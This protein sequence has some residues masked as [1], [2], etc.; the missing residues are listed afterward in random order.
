MQSRD[1]PELA[2]A[3]DLHGYRAAIERALGVPIRARSD[4]PR[5]LSRAIFRRLQERGVE[6]A[7]MAI[8]LRS[9]SSGNPA[10]AVAL[11]AR[12][13]SI[14]NRGA[15]TS[16]PAR[17]RPE[18]KAE[19]FLTG[20]PS[21]PSSPSFQPSSLRSS[22][23]GMSPP[24]DGHEG[25]RTSGHAVGTAKLAPEDVHS[26]SARLRARLIN[27]LSRDARFAGREE[28]I[29][30]R[31][32]ASEGGR[33]D[34]FAVQAFAGCGVSPSGDPRWDPRNACTAK[35][36]AS[37]PSVRDGVRRIR[38]AMRSPAGTAAPNP[39]PEL[40][41][42]DEELLEFDDNLSTR[43]RV[44]AKLRAKKRKAARRSRAAAKAVGVVTEEAEE[45]APPA[46][47]PAP[48]QRR[49]R[50][51][52]AEPLV[53]VG[54]GAKEPKEL[55]DEGAATGWKEGWLASTG[56]VLLRRS[57]PRPANCP[58]LSELGQSGGRRRPSSASFQPADLPPDRP[59]RS[60]QHQRLQE[61]MA[62]ARHRAASRRL[63]SQQGTSSSLRD[64]P[65][66]SLA[67]DPLGQ[68][69]ASS[70]SSSSRH[71]GPP[72]QAWTARGNLREHG[73]SPAGT[74][75]PAHSHSGSAS[76]RH[77]GSPSSSTAQ[78]IALEAAQRRLALAARAAKSTRPD[79]HRI[80]AKARNQQ[81]DMRSAAE[82]RARA[83]TQRMQ[84]MVI[85]GPEATRGASTAFRMT[86]VSSGLANS[87]SKNPG[88]RALMQAASSFT[89]RPRR[90][91]KCGGGGRWK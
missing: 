34:P 68:L 50:V 3:P 43:G 89:V 42:D 38:A 4:N 56:G 80:E 65:G 17:H 2:H 9:P 33:P 23:P 32:L 36:S 11:R 28:Q 7:R 54:L 66:Y 5:E 10:D 81:A 41:H 31:L 82:M 76:H 1:R 30:E 74:A 64:G 69:R 79:M 8:A 88:N 62:Q 48:P 21:W 6:P 87:P 24:C 67:I 15:H 83:R 71:R 57:C 78:E 86:S 14:P 55:R 47:P 19:G 40:D 18:G 90:S 44:K 59:S 37:H 35:G 61:Q 58:S 84:S 29:A 12:R 39:A 51:A 53:E 75:K 16:R 91:C 49:R 46:A 13:P 60:I 70:S 20:Q 77:H 25:A 26:R 72:Q 52:F 22:G 63:R 73:A 27:K 45:V 85:Q